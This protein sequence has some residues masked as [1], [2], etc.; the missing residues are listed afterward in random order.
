MSLVEDL[1]AEMTKVK[2]DSKGI[3]TDLENVSTYFE[4]FSL[5]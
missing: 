4:T 2:E 3:R 5:R 1:M